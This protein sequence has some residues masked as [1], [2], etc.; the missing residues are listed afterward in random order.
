MQSAHK[1]QDKKHRDELEQQRR[2][3]LSKMEE[4]INRERRDWDKTRQE[5]QDVIQQ[6]NKENESL[7]SENLIINIKGNSSC[8]LKL[9][10]T[11]TL[12]YFTSL[13]LIIVC[14][15]ICTICVGFFVRVKRLERRV[16]IQLTENNHKGQRLEQKGRELDVR[17]SWVQQREFQ[18][19]QRESA[20]VV[21]SQIHHSSK[22]I[23]AKRTTSREHRKTSEVQRVGFA[24]T[25]EH[26]QKQKSST[27]SSGRA[28]EVP[29]TAAIHKTTRRAK[30]TT[31]RS[32]RLTWS[33][34]DSMTDNNTAI[35]D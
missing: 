21:Q 30:P 13:S 17:T 14:G 8:H 6:L 2:E 35:R 33:N 34:S 27:G 22:H 5:Y 31:T 19:Q 32:T 1:L 16:S 28:T 20:V 3:L 11:L 10:L 23:V 7:K 29:S 18:V 9:Y 15:I 12:G 24:K 4:V 25:G 26:L